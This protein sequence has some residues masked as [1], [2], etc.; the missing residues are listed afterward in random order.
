MKFGLGPPLKA[1]PAGTGCS[2]R[3]GIGQRR[4]ANDGSC[5]W[6]WL[7]WSR[8]IPT[9][10][11]QDLAVVNVTESQG[12][13]SDERDAFGLAEKLRQGNLERR[14]FKELGPY[15]K[16]RELARVYAMVVRHVVRVQNRIK[17]FTRSRGVEVAGK[18]VY[19]LS[20][21]SDSGTGV[22]L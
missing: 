2:G 6:R 21:R 9:P 10:H 17:S 4:D 19:S 12:P 11:A 8:E 22:A 3:R 15:R 18:T 7:W 1:A 14:V 20:Q 16:L 13:K 5:N